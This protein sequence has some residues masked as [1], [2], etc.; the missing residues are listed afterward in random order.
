[1]KPAEFSG[2]KKKGAPESKSTELETDRMKIVDTCIE[3]NQLKIVY[4]QSFSL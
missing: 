2:T 3:M 4:H 1:M